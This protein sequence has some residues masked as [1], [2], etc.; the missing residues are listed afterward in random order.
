MCTPIVHRSNCVGE[1]AQK[2]LMFVS[3]GVCGLYRKNRAGRKKI[4]CYGND[5]GEVIPDNFKFIKL[6]IPV[7]SQS[8]IPSVSRLNHSH[9]IQIP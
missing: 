4:L 2:S 1:G 7:F 5:C 8:L 9:Q 6:V 3:Y